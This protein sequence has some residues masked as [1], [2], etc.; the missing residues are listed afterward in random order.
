MAAFLPTITAPLVAEAI[1][2]EDWDTAKQRVCE[3]LFLSNVLGGVFSLVLIGFPKVVLRMVLPPSLTDG[4]SAVVGSGAA[5]MTVLDYA[6]VCDDY[7]YIY[8]FFIWP[9]KTKAKKNN[10]MCTIISLFQIS[11][12][13]TRLSHHSHT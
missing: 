10:L 2:K 1:G 7:L 3:S 5:A 6:V 11:S 13:T 9:G 4:G 12:F 8:Y